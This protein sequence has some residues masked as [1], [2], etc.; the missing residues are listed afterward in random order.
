MPQLGVAGGWVVPA[1]H[2]RCLDASEW[3]FLSPRG[4]LSQ[5]RPEPVRAVSGSSGPDRPWHLRDG[6]DVPLPASVPRKPV[7]SVGTPSSV[8]VASRESPLLLVSGPVSV[9]TVRTPTNPVRCEIPKRLYR[10]AYSWVYSFSLLTD[11]SSFPLIALK[12]LIPLKIP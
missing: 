1:F 9:F 10:D 11:I 4:C 2:D 6:C 5:D 12:F 8:R 7:G 3:V